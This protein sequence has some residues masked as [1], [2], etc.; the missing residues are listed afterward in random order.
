MTKDIYLTNPRL[1]LNS[2]NLYNCMDGNIRVLSDDREYDIEQDIQH[3]F[4]HQ[5]LLRKVHGDD[6]I[7]L[8]ECVVLASGSDRA[9][10]YERAVKIAGNV[11]MCLGTLDEILN[12]RPGP[13]TAYNFS[14][15]R[16]S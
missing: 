2:L 15:A 5:D 4:E 6:T 3:A 8:R 12:H 14:R 1:Y 16:A 7:S 9:E 11:G 13:A 10:V